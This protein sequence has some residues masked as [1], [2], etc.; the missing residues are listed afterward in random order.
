MGFR[1]NPFGLHFRFCHRIGSCPAALIVSRRPFDT[2]LRHYNTNSCIFHKK[3]AKPNNSSPPSSRLPG[4]RLHSFASP[5]RAGAH[6]K[7]TPAARLDTCWTPV[8][9]NY[10]PGLEDPGDRCHC[11]LNEQIW[12]RILMNSHNRTCHESRQAQT[13]TRMQCHTRMDIHMHI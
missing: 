1:L 7:N 4:R 6:P 3:R 10:A 13:R 11:E 5:H 12:R 9:H 2:R 8:W